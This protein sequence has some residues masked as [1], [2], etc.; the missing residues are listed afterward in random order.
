[1]TVNGMKDLRADPYVICRLEQFDAVDNVKRG[2]GR[3]VVTRAS[4][5]GE[6][7][8]EALTTYIIPC[9]H[10]MWQVAV[11]ACNVR[12]ISMLHEVMAP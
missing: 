12:N 11:K 4:A 2:S 7:P 10:N 3:V 1:M 6:T 8:H 5:E 9:F